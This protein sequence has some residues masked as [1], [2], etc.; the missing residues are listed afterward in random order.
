MKRITVVTPNTAGLWTLDKQPFHRCIL[1]AS[2]Q[3][4]LAYGDFPKIV[5]QIKDVGGNVIWRSVRNL[6]PTAQYFT[7]VVF[8]VQG[9]ETTASAINAIEEF[10]CPLPDDL[11]IPA[12]YTFTITLND[13]QPGQDITPNLVLTTDDPFLDGARPFDDLQAP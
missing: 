6:T 9:C 10:G 13:H 7:N 5:A 2:I 12:N 11:T 3:G 8:S 4:I 1:V